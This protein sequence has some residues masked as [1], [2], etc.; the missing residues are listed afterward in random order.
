MSGP[1]AHSRLNN[2]RLNNPKS[3]AGKIPHEMWKT[4]TAPEPL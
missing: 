1:A 2:P 3:L 4:K